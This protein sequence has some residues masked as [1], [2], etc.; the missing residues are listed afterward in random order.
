MPQATAAAL[1]EFRLIDDGQRLAIHRVAIDDAGAVVAFDPE[2][3]RFE[4]PSGGINA[5]WRITGD[6]FGAA[7]CTFATVPVLL[8]RDGKLIEIAA[9]GGEDAEPVRARKPALAA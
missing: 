2:P 7:N 9:H 1:T 6:A 8:L 3:A 4:V 5:R